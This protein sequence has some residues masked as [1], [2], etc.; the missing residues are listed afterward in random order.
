[1]K[2]LKNFLDYSQMPMFEAVRS[3]DSSNM[4]LLLHHDGSQESAQKMQ[5]Y[6]DELMEK[7]S[8]PEAIS[9]G[10]QLVTSGESALKYLQ[11]AW[12]ARKS[13]GVDKGELRRVGEWY[14]GKGAWRINS[15][16]AIKLGMKPAWMEWSDMLNKAP[17]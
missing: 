4:G 8:S 12:E 5:R 6:A 13:A 11:D 16:K 14:I 7:S 3:I 2:F 15:N 9:K 17:N 10:K 1:M